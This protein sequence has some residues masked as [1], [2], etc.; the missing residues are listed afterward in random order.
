MKLL[1]EFD[2]WKS[3]LCTCP[4]KYSL[5]VY[6]GCPHACVYCYITSYIKSGFKCRIKRNLLP[7]LRKELENE[8]WEVKVVTLS[9]SSDPYPKIEEKLKL[10]RKCIE[11]LREFGWK[12]LIVTKSDLVTRDID[13]LK[14]V[15]VV[16]LT[17][18]TINEKLSTL[19]E[20]NA[21]PPRKRLEAIKKLKENSI[22]VCV[23]IDPIIPHL[24]DKPS[25]IEKLVRFLS[26]LKVDHVISSTYKARS[27]SLARLSMRFPKLYERLR[28]LYRRG[29]KI[30]NYYYLPKDLRYEL[31]SKVKSICSKYGISF[32]CCREGFRELNDNICDGSFLLYSS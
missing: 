19:L 2:P 30:S 22:P 20:P 11:M 6:T 26:K 29:E 18:T 31:M 24:N 5:N 10:T 32:A 9:A 7:R 1:N 21:P 13:L 8:K 12:L 17:I 15:S 16:S 3:K 28:E 4:K 25:E 14:G 27:D 23:R